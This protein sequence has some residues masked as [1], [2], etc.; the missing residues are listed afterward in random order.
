M[1]SSSSI[2]EPGQPC[3]MISGNASGAC[4]LTWMK[5]IST[6]SI[7]VVNCGSAFSFAWHRR[8][9]YSLAQYRASS[10][11]VA[12]WTPCDRSATSS[13]PGQRAAAMRRRRSAIAS[14]GTPTRKGRISVSLDISLRLS[15]QRP[16]A[17]ADLFGEDLR[18]FPGREVAAPVGL[19]V[20]DEVVIGPL[21][22]APRGLVA[23]AGKGA[24]G[25]RDRHIDRV[26]EGDLVFPVQAGRGDRRVRQPV[27]RD[28]VQD[29]V[30]GQGA[31]GMPV[32]GVPE[33]GRGDRR[34]GLPV[35]VTVVQKPGSQADG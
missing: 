25:R 26:V 33:H 30:P 20:V 11:T 31:C 5:W 6:P 23:L 21:G 17:R 12:S 28:V 2:T 4:D 27:Q 19:V 10:W 14:S 16:Q 18:L 32:D 15:A 13:L 34:R 1:T 3:V 29:I 8:H 35:T 9:S 24:D 22:P 7:W